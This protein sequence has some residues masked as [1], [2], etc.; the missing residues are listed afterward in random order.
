MELTVNAGIKSKQE[1]AERLMAGEVFWSS[2]HKI[3]YDE[4]EVNP[5]RVGTS[6]LNGCWDDFKGFLIKKE[7]TETIPEEGVL[8][9]VSDSVDKAVAGRYAIARVVTGYIPTDKYSYRTETGDCEYRYATPVKP[10]DCLGD[11]DA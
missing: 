10:S 5:F 4:R 3:Y 1:L 11:S 2:D 9:W 7:W 8:C 6:A